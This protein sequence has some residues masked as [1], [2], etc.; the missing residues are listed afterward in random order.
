MNLAT[1]WVYRSAN[2]V[3]T[4]G[5]LRSS[6]KPLVSFHWHAANLLTLIKGGS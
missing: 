3:D 6:P 4:V 2:R 1:Q 5:H